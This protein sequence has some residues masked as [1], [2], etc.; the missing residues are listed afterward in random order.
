MTQNTELLYFNEDCLLQ[1]FPN[2]DGFTDP[3]DL[4]RFRGECQM[5]REA[6]QNLARYAEA[7]HD[8]MQLRTDGKIE[9][10]LRLEESAD[11]IFSQ[12]PKW[13]RW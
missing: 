6:I 9:D 5:V 3:T 10:A 13:A 12:L 7:K 8:A 1:A 2:L 11:R 4:G